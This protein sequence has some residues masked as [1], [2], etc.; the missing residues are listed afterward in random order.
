MAVSQV[1][2]LKNPCRVWMWNSLVAS[3]PPPSAPATPIRQVRMR[4][5]DLLPGI[6][7]LASRPP[8]RPRT[9][10]AMM[11]IT[12]SSV[13]DE[14]DMRGSRSRATGRGGRNDLP[15]APALF[16]AAAPFVA[17]GPNT[18]KKLRFLN[19]PPYSGCSCRGPEQLPHITPAAALVSIGGI[20][21]QQSRGREDPLACR[22]TWHETE[23]EGDGLGHPA[24]ALDRPGLRRPARR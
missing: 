2:R 18:K 21:L 7:I 6:S 4:P 23:A 17:L 24:G 19:C 10:H 11:P 9:I 15:R 13:S 8:P 14:I 1:E 12:D 20:S 5:C 16:W 3:Q 22:Q